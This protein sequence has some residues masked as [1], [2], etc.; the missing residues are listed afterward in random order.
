M[1]AGEERTSVAALT[2]INPVR[3]GQK[4]TQ[5]TRCTTDTRLA[6]LTRSRCIALLHLA[7]PPAPLHL[8]P[9]VGSELILR[10]SFHQ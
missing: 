2:G 8:D 4:A 6:V 9:S 3:P 5:V 10:I 7:Y 1:C